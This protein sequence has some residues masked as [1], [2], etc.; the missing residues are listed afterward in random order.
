VSVAQLAPATRGSQRLRRSYQPSINQEKPMLDRQ[1][2]SQRAIAEAGYKVR[3]LEDRGAS[4]D[5]SPTP[6][7]IGFVGLGHMGTAMA[8]NLVAAGCRVIGY[9]R[10]QE[11]MGKVHGLGVSPTMDLSELF[12]SEIVISMLPD[13]DT[14]RGVMFGHEDNSDGLAAGL[15]PGAIHLS[16][17]TISTAAAA[18]F[19]SEHMRR[20]Q[21]YVAAPV[22]GNPDAARA[23]QLF[24]VAAGAPVDVARCR[25]LTDS[26]GQTFVVGDDPAQ[27]NLIKLLGNMMT[28][29][30]LEVLGEIV[31]VFRKRGLEPQPFIDIM[32]ATMFGGRVHRIYGGKI[33]DESY[34]PGLAM[35]LALKDVRLAL[36]EAEKA[37][38]P[39]PSVSVVRD[40]LITGISR[41]YAGLDWT[42]LGLVA[43]DEAGIGARLP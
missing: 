42:A 27:A 4:A 1:S 32:T 31:A 20:G 21:G 19:A 40:R 43:A 2:S 23:R 13:D 14:V 38:V 25:L 6:G 29:T 30:A 10:R 3:R 8:A 36:A 33:V 12:D 18:E 17:S 7:R 41:G 5:R 35:P 15:R 28:A 24:V 26:L 16:M 9:V 11:Q 34:A 39:M 37:G 22:F